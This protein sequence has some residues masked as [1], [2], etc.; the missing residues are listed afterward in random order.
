MADHGEVE[1]R[2]VAATGRG[3][4]LVGH[5]DFD[6]RSFPFAAR[7]RAEGHVALAAKRAIA[8]DVDG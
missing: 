5:E 6:G 4:A 7:P 1:G 3:R 8:W 2:A